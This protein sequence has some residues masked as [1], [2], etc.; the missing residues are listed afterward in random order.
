MR[1][2]ATTLSQNRFRSALQVRLGAGI[3][4]SVAL[5]VAAV[6]LLVEGAPALGAV[7]VTLALAAGVYT[8]VIADNLV[9][10]PSSAPVSAEPVAAPQH[11]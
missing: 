10:A 5:A 1:T 11:V 8:T 4:A 3:L 2:H 6:L 7:A 9:T